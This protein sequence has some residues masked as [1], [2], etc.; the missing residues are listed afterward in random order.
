[1][2]IIPKVPKTARIGCFGTGKDLL[3]GALIW[4]DHWKCDRASICQDDWWNMLNALTDISLVS[5][6]SL[7]ELNACNWAYS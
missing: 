4:S 6:K 7:R 1:M 3:P 5:I 2:A